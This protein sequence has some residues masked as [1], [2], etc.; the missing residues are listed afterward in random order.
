M[1]M[2]ALF[3]LLKKQIAAPKYDIQLS[4]WVDLDAFNHLAD[5]GVVILKSTL[6]PFGDDSLNLVEAVIGRIVRAGKLL[7]G[8]DSVL[9]ERNRIRDLFELILAARFA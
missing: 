4:A 2:I 1:A 7:Y 9:E 8:V 5:N 3:A 6:L